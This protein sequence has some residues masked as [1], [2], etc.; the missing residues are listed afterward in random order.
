MLW[1]REIDVSGN[2]LCFSP[3][4]KSVLFIY[5]CSLGVSLRIV[6]LDSRSCIDMC[7]KMKENQGHLEYVFANLCSCSVFRA[8][9]PLLYT[10]CN[11]AS[12]GAHSARLVPPHL[13]I[14]CF[15][16][17]SKQNVAVPINN[18]GGGLRGTHP[19]GVGGEMACHPMGAVR[20]GFRAEGG[21]A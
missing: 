9:H 14:L 1:G 3:Y 11:R 20:K 5:A 13:T 15:R 18:V 2:I 12:V 10:S 16:N 7:F 19:F 8:N 4:Y 6:L 17:P 21:F